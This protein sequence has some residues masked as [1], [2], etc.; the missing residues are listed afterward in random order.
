LWRA[1][2]ALRRWSL[3]QVP[4]GFWETQG[5]PKFRGIRPKGEKAIGHRAVG[6]HDATIFLARRLS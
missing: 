6:E 4:E 2:A 3:T 5:N 1:I